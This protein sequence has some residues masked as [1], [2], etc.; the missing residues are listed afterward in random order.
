[1]IYDYECEHCGAEFEFIAP[2]KE[3]DIPRYCPYCDNFRPCRKIIKVGHG[4]VRRSDSEWVRD[5]GMSLEQPFN[6][7]DDLRVF[8]ERNPN[9]VPK[10][11]HPALPSSIGD[12]PSPPTEKEFMRERKR[13][14]A[15][16]LFEIRRIEI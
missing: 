12:V 14:A 13:L 7:V 8:L 10:E 6:T 15:K 3:C 2:A 9:I 5:A 1:M 4:G 16:K 11:S